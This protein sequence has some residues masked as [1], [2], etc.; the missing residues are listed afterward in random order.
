MTF[1]LYEWGGLNR[2][3]FESINHNYGPHYDNMMLM[4]SRAGEPQS[5]KFYL[6]AL[7]ICL[8]GELAMQKYKR[9]AIA[10]E[11]WRN[12]FAMLILMM[13]GYAAYGFVVGAMKSVIDLPRPFMIPE[14][15]EAMHFIGPYPNPAEYNASFP[16]AHA[17]TMAFIVTALWKRFD[18]PFAHGVGIVM[19]LLVSWSRVAVGMQFPADVAAGALVGWSMALLIRRYVFS[20]MHAS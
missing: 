17:A 18:D 16:S 7:V 11:Q 13:M 9:Q 10:R 1:V 6:A 19:V 4:L 20:M 2:L 8:F 3:L 14:I 12:A 15:R 5:F